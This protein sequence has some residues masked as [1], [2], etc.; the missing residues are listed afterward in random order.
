MIALTFRCVLAFVIGALAALA[1]LYTPP[2]VGAVLCFALAAVVLGVLAWRNRN[3]PASTTITAPGAFYRDDVGEVL[4]THDGKKWR[5]TH[6]VDT[7][8]VRCV[9]VTR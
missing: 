4:Q 1:I 7:S 2:L 9:E 5:I 6:V 3:V 8:T